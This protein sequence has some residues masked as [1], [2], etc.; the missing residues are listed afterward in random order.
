MQTF[1]CIEATAAVC[2]A[3][4]GA[5]CHDSPSPLLMRAAIEAGAVQDDAAVSPQG[6]ALIAERLDVY[7]ARAD[8]PTF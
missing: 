2:L 1:K 5:G 8:A 3:L 6:P 7:I 4:A